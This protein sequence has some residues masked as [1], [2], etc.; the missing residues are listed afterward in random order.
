MSMSEWEGFGLTVIQSRIISSSIL[1]SDLTVVPFLS[2]LTLLSSDL[3]ALMSAPTCVI[4]RSFFSFFS[5][6]VLSFA[7]CLFALVMV[8]LGGLSE[9]ED[10]RE[11]SLHGAQY[12]L[13]LSGDVALA[14]C[15]PTKMLRAESKAWDLKTPRKGKNKS[16]FLACRV[17]GRGGVLEKCAVLG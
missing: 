4:L 12:V 2:V 11:G 6:P 17:E 13:A 3:N 7:P 8:A 14:V 9:S 10:S 16:I 15:S 1:S 5:A